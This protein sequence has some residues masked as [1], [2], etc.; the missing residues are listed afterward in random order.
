MN[1]PQPIYTTGLIRICVQCRQLPDGTWLA[2]VPALCHTEAAGKTMQEAAD[3]A[4][5]AISVDP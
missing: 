5:R 3:N 2:H 1:K 4:C